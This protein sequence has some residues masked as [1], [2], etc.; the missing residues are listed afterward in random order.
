VTLR[1]AAFAALALYAALRWTSLLAPQPAGRAWLS[2]LVGLAGGGALVAARSLPSRVRIA[3]AGAAAIG[4]LALAFLV[5]GVPA[6]TLWPKH[7]G[8]LLSGVGQGFDA[9]PTMLV[10]YRGAPDGW[11]WRLVLLGGTL[12]VALAALAAFWPRARGAGRPW[13]AAATL[14]VLA[15]VPAVILPDDHA[16]LH[17]AILLCGL[18]AFLALERVQVADAPVA[19]GAVALVALVAVVLLP[20]LDRPKPW[21]DYEAAAESLSPHRVAFEF[22][23]DYGPITWPRTGDEMFRV[24]AKRSSYWKAENL[25]Y[26][27]GVAWRTGEGTT[28]APQAA[29]FDL[30][31]RSRAR[32][33]DIRTA[34]VTIRG[35][36]SRDVIGPGDELAVLDAPGTFA[37]NVGAGLYHWDSELDEGDSYQVRSFVASPTARQMRAAGTEYDS[38]VTG[39][40]TSEDRTVTLPAAAALDRGERGRVARL[41]A[42]SGNLPAQVFPAWGSPRIPV[43]DDA[44]RRAVE[45]SAYAGVW[46]LAQRLKRGAAT[47]YDYAQRIESYLAGRAFSYTESPP[48]AGLPLVDFLLRSKRGYCQH[49]SGAMALLLR[50]GGVPARVAGGFSP[51]RL[52]PDSGEWVVTDLDAH[53]WVEMFVPGRGW[54]TFDPTPPAAPARGQI[55]LDVGSGPLASGQDGQRRGEFLDPNRRLGPRFSGP[56]GSLPNGA[57]GPPWALI[58]VGALL[59]IGV[60]VLL[61]RWLRRPGDDPGE[62]AVLELERALRLTG[63]P[64]PAGTTLRQLER[65]LASSGDA[66]GY[67]RSVRELRYGVAGEGP[68]AAERRGLR[69]ELARGLG[70][71]GTARAWWAVPPRR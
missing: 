8:E 14:A 24:R 31:A 58:V 67:V 57:G 28:S 21:F 23:H 61:F 52:D 22:D 65:R 64:A 29:R 62:W 26:F 18:V 71:A 16:A 40:F 46:R 33:R 35:L 70:A 7:W 5:A 47:P 51:G 4:T 12:L 32:P 49:F 48:Q 50:M 69:R 56:E 27:N 60:A 20:A 10:P 25:E 55:T 53:S 68:T 41:V 38:A 54:A 44:V 66:A 30:D 43:I 59:A 45:S 3:A 36:R 13:L 6:R 39:D 2:V 9:L 1:F 63:R 34:R 42:E 19:A 15:G 11:P 17:G 37:P